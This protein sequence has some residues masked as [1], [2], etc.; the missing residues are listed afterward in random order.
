MGNSVFFNLISHCFCVG[1]KYIFGTYKASEKKL[2]AIFTGRNY[3]I[4]EANRQYSVLSLSLANEKVSF[5]CAVGGWTLVVAV[6]A[7]D[8]FVFDEFE[9]E[10]FN[11]FLQRI[12]R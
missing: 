8:H 10:F 5:D 4:I 9:A 3:C 11:D 1:T 12:Q 6:G 7:I 2:L